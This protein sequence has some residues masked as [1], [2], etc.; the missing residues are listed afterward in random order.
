MKTLE[1]KT[2]VRPTAGSIAGAG[3]AATARSSASFE[4]ARR[5]PRVP[6][7]DSIARTNTVLALKDVAPSAALL[8][9]AIAES[10]FIEP[11]RALR[12]RF[13]SGR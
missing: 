7:T 11:V 13:R 3:N 2:P 6:A 5:S 9:M 12:R 8:C 1:V 4:A 10:V